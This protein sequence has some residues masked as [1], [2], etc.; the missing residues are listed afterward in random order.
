[1]SEDRPAES[2]FGLLADETRLDV[3]RAVAV[4]QHEQSHPNAGPVELAFSEIYDRVDVDN[5]SKLSYHLGELAG[6]FLR[7]SEE[8]YSFTYAGERLARFVL[9]G[10]YGDPPAFG[11]EPVD[12]TCVFCGETSLEASLRNRFF[13]V[14]CP[15]CDE[16]VLGHPVTPAEVRTRDGEELIDAVKRASAHLF[17]EIQSGACPECGG[18]LATAVRDMSESP[19]PDADPFVAV[20]DCDACLAQFNAPLTYRVAYHPASVAFHWDRGVDVTATGLWEF[21]EHV[22]EGRW[23]AERVE[24]DPARYEAVLRR[25]TDA[26]RVRLDEDARVTGTERV[27]REPAGDGYS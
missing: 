8:G 19:L 23:T 3:L 14:D 18:R 17:R 27:R 9:S 15:S 4:A 20:S 12:G 6:P 10:N 16:Q 25:G 11:P 26:L 21:H 22:Y 13:R 24:T 5:T 7:K 2:V 1:M